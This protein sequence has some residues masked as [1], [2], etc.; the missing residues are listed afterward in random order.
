MGEWSITDA[1]S[2]KEPRTLHRVLDR[3][4]GEQEPVSTMKVEKNVPSGTAAT[5][6]GLCFVENHVLPFKAFQVNA[7]R[8]DEVVRGDDDVERRITIVYDG[9][10]RPEFTKSF[11]IGDSAPIGHDFQ[12]RYESGE[13]LLPIVESRGR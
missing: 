4:T 11:A 8:D 7:V 12:S 6:D 2:A 3:S 1:Y 5:L 9:L 10:L 13:F